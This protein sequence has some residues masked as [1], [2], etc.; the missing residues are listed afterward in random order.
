MKRYQSHKQI[1][2]CQRNFKMLRSLFSLYIILFLNAGVSAFDL[3][4]P[5]GIKK[6]PSNKNLVIK[7]SQPIKKTYVNKSGVKKRAMLVN[8]CIRENKYSEIINEAG[9][10]YKVDEQLIRAIISTESCFNPK[11]VSP[12]G[13]QGLMQLMPFTAKRFGVTNSF[14]P[15]QNIMGGVKYLRSLLKRFNGNPSLAIAA[16]NAGEGAVDYY[17]GV[18]PYKE[19]QDYVKKVSGLLGLKQTRI[20]N[21]KRVGERKIVT[22]KCSSNKKIRSHTYAYYGEKYVKRYYLVRPNDTLLKISRRV[23]IDVATI[24]VLN[25]LKQQGDFKSNQMRTLLLSSCPL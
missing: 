16:Y 22:M 14:D 21:K 15:A 4:T 12:K 3:V 5:S 20:K 9:R 8:A 24:E 25:K 10:R 19:T 17:G 11:A 7:V 23:G 13:A 18:P 2:C 1:K 6:T